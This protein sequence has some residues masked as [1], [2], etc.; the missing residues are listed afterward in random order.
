MK[1]TT[2][3]IPDEL[4]AHLRF[5]A[6]RRGITISELTR[7]AIEAHLGVPAGRRFR[8]QG[9]VAS[10]IGDLSERVEE[11]LEEWARTP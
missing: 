10:G 8:S 6:A 2:V 5:E 11:I 3:K 9:A 4:D 1:R 7:E